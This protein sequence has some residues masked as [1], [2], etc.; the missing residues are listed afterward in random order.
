MGSVYQD[1]A[2]TPTNSAYYH[3]VPPLPSRPN[4]FYNTSNILNAAGESTTPAAGDNYAEVDMTSYYRPPPPV[5]PS[6]PSGFY[7]FDL[8]FDTNN[9]PSMSPTNN[10]SSTGAGTGV[11]GMPERLT[12]VASPPPIP[13]ATRPVSVAPPPKTNDNG[14]RAAVPPTPLSTYS[15]PPLPTISTTTNAFPSQDTAN[16]ASSR[17]P[18]SPTSGPLVGGRTPRSIH[19]SGGRRQ[20]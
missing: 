9:N 10:F 14:S 18:V 16:F 1:P 12:G 15:P 17:S 11:G 20:A 3:P 5:A 2:Q 19:G 7:D 4:S 6:T 8:G 13:R